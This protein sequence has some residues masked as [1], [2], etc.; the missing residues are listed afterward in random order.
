MKNIPDK[1]KIYH[2][3]HVDKLVSVLNDQFLWSDSEMVNC[4]SN[5]G[6]V[7][8]MNKIKQRRLNE[9]K[10]TCYPDLTVGSCVPFYFCPRSIM[11]YIIHKANHP[12]LSYKGGQEPI[13]HLEADLYKAAD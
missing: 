11:L 1:P 13:I 3:L 9:L 7:I 6:T 12:E 4:S 2:I 8:G 10:L 5:K